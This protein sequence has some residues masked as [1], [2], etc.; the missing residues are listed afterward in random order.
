M[1]ETYEMHLSKQTVQAILMALQKVTIP[2]EMAPI[3]VQAQQEIQQ[4]LTPKIE[5][6]TKPK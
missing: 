4:A 6:Q 5:A 3:I 2:G 1:K